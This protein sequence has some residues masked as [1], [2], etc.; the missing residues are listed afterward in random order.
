[1]AN[2]LT[3][4]QSITVAGDSVRQVTGSTRPINLAEQLLL[5]GIF[6]NQQSAA[7]RRNVAE[8][9]AIGVQRFNFS[10]DPTFLT[11]VGSGTTMG[12]LSSVIRQRAV[13][14]QSVLSVNLKPS[15]SKKPAKKTA[16]KSL[17]KSR[18]PK[19]SKKGK[20]K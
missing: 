3:A 9:A 6:N 1:M 7:V 8:D 2:K 5:Y 20:T 11:F 13:P 12:Q 17:T 10:I 18:K 4:Q 16:K 15:S 14:N 19:N